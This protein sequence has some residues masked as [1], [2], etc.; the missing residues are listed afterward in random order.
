MVGKK[1]ILILQTLIFLNLNFQKVQ[2]K[3]VR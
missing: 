1:L 2:K 3:A